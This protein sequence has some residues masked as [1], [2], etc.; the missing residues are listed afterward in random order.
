MQK[1]I[2]QPLAFFHNHYFRKAINQH[3]Q[4]TNYLL[5][6]YS[7]YPAN[8][9]SANLPTP[10]GEKLDSPAEIPGFIRFL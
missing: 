3:M 5:H 1:E 4:E 8:G 2:P 7:V 6:F 9:L 10:A